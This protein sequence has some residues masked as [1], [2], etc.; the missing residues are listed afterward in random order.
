MNK[1]IHLPRILGA[2][3]T[4]L[5]VLA[6]CHD[7][8]A[9]VLD[10]TQM[11]NQTLVPTTYSFVWNG[12]IV[13]QRT[14]VS[15]TFAA[16]SE[17]ADKMKMSISG[18]IPS[19][20]EDLTLDVGVTSKSDEIQYEGKLNVSLYGLNVSGIYFPSPSGHYFKMKCNYQVLS[21]VTFDTPCEL[22]AGDKN[23]NK[24][25]VLLTFKNNGKVNVD[26]T[27]W[28]DG[29]ETTN[30]FLTSYWMSK[31]QG[32]VILELTENQAL[33]LVTSWNTITG[34]DINSLMIKY[35]ETN[36]YALYMESFSDSQLKLVTK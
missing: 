35:G 14:D 27:V 10:S 8:D 34:E 9:S 20:D 15:A 31:N 33:S 17:Q 29:K 36:R 32:Q 22:V 12:N 6:S 30:S 13:E 21:G 25:E 3:L 23:D 26:I 1:K 4:A 16:V 7:D 24:S 18:I 5:L 11:L 2:L 28:Q 19:T